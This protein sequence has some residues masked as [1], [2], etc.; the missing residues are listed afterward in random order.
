VPFDSCEVLEQTAPLGSRR[1]EPH[2]S[3]SGPAS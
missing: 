1:R 2:W 3:M